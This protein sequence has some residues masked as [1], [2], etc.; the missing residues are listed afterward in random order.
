MA[1][2]R[3]LGL[4]LGLACAI[5]GGFL[6]PALAQ[7]TAGAQFDL[8]RAAFIAK[9]PLFIRDSR[10]PNHRSA[11]DQSFA[12]AVLHDDP[13]YDSLQELARFPLGEGHTIRV[14]KIDELEELNDGEILVFPGSSRR[15][16]SEVLDRIRSARTIVITD[17]IPL[18]K[19][20]IMFAVAEEHSRIKL[21][22]N[23]RAVE[24]A[25]LV[26]DYRLAAVARFIEN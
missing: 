11:G 7:S 3:S 14:R 4:S 10:L 20:G 19:K 5:A 23:Q 18:C 13:I 26:L 12:L 6:S 1:L 25:G 24:E 17:S 22:V 9:L 2:S 16:L 8:V 15:S 21:F